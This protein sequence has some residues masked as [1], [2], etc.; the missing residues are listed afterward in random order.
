M[1]GTILDGVHRCPETGAIVIIIGAGVGGLQA[2]I[3]C[4]RK[5]F[6]VVVLEAVKEISPQGENMSCIRSTTSKPVYRRLF[7]YTSI[8]FDHV[9]G[10][11]KH[12]RRLP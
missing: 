4:W 8:C 2:A 1:T 11:P 5:G 7:Y 3:E 6:D 12:V 10:L 9:E